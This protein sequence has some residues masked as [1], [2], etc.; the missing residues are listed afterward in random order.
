MSDTETPYEEEQFAYD[1]ASQSLV[2]V[3]DPDTGTIV[4]QEPAMRDLITRSDGNKVCGFDP[5]TLTLDVVYVGVDEGDKEYRM[6]ETRIRTDEALI[7][8]AARLTQR[9][10]IAAEVDSD[11][12]VDATLDEFQE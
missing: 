10:G 6:P 11:L 1:I 4:D 3:V 5:D 2:K 7:E 8:A 9:G 12:R